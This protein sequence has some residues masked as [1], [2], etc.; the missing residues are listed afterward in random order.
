MR[1]RYSETEK[2]NH[3][4]FRRL[5]GVKRETFS[6]MVTIL[7]MSYVQKRKKGGHQSSLSVEDMLLMTL[8]YLREYRT[9]FHIANSY[10][11]S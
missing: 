2:L 6:K 8:E 7:K 3:E 11:I 1:L 9:Y 4:K 5:T 10:G